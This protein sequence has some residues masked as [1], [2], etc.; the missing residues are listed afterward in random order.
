MEDHT[1]AAGSQFMPSTSTRPP[2]LHAE[3]T[4]VALDVLGAGIARLEVRE[5]R[6]EPQHRGTEATADPIRQ[7]LTEKMLADRWVCSVARL[8]RWRTI[9]EGP[10]LL[11]ILGKVSYRIKDIEAYEEACLILKVLYVS[12]QEA[13]KGI[14]NGSKGLEPVRNNPGGAGR[15][16][17]KTALGQENS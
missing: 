4:R 7:V 11:K 15:M 2:P 8:Q 10:P 13:P 12:A 3:S 5:Q 16:D 14:G 17:F 9:G 1:Q 6:P